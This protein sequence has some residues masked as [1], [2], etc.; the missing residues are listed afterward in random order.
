[1]ILFNKVESGKSQA[2]G[3]FTVLLGVADRLRWH[4]V[5]VELSDTPDAG[6][7]TVSVRSPGATDFVDIDGAIDLTGTELLKVF[8]PV[9]AA[10]LKFTPTDLD[11]SPLVTY[12]VIV[13][14]G[15]G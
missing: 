6:D 15:V 3:P 14:S 1:M 11:T 8:G 12:N 4:Q 5:Q 10:E 9:F 7:L 2:D 13:T